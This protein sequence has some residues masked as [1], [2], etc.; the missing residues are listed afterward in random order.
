MERRILHKL[1]KQL[2]E[3]KVAEAT[4]GVDFFSFVG[5]IFV[6]MAFGF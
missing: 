1:P 6:P 3:G 4:G 5:A 2:R